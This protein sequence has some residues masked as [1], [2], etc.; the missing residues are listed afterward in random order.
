MIAFSNQDEQTRVSHR[1]E[2]F[3]LGWELAKLFCGGPR[4]LVPRLHE[5]KLP[6]PSHRKATV[7]PTV[8]LRK[9][10]AQFEAGHDFG[11]A[12]IK[13]ATKSALY[14]HHHI[15]NHLR[16][17]PDRRAGTEFRIRPTSRN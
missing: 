11:D 5:T 17:I 12:R 9:Y 3:N 2:S 7:N 10:E 16:A 6:R 14:A 13:P 15:G 1:L 8:P 4:L